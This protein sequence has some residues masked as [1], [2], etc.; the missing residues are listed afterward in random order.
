MKRDLTQPVTISP[1]TIAILGL[2]ASEAQP[3]P[4]SQSNY[5]Y[6]G[7]IDY[8]INAA[9]R[10]SCKFTYFQNESPFNASTFVQT[11]VSQTY[12]FKDRAPAYSAQLI[13]TVSRNTV[14]ELR[15]QNPKPYQ[16]QVAFEGTGPQPVL[17]ISGV[18]N[19]GGPDQIGVRF[20]EITPEVS[21]SRRQHDSFVCQVHVLRA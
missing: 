4:F 7:K 5:F 9:N 6:L 2:P 21:H 3:I 15:F 8:Q 17:F 11:L 18:A 14:N 1:G 10:L 20:I 19:F 12:L 16:R 13:S